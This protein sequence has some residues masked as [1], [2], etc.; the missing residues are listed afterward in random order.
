MTDSPGERATIRIANQ[1]DVVHHVEVEAGIAKET[2]VSKMVQLEAGES[3][4]LKE[5]LPPPSGRQRYH[6]T[7]R[8]N[9]GIPK[10]DSHVRDDGF[11]ILKL[12]IE[13]GVNIEWMDAT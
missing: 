1:D 10:S 4:D 8:L 3:I 9:D 5:T 12:T 13:T 11:N 6:V 2:V 7:V